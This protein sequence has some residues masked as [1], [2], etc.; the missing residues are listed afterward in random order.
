MA[1]PEIPHFAMPFHLDP[2]HVAVVEQDTIVDVMDC[3]EAIVRTIV[4]ERLELPDFGRDDWMFEVQPVPTTALQ[5]SIAA[6]E[7][8]AITTIEQYPD[9]L[10][11]LIA[12]IQIGVSQAEEVT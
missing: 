5:Q 9:A 1:L 10:D 3:V 11:Q 4:G 12:V 7:P 8:R 6:Q 2:P